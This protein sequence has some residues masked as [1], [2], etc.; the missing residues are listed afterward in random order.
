MAMT[1]RQ[2][3]LRKVFFRLKVVCWTSVEESDDSAKLS[4]VLQ[5]LPD[6]YLSHLSKLDSVAF[7]YSAEVDVLT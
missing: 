6:K 5:S 7:N 4:V 3:A 1:W 2:S